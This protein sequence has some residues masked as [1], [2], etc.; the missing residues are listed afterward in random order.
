MPRVYGPKAGEKEKMS[1]ILA[2]KP[3][4][5]RAGTAEKSPDRFKPKVDIVAHVEKRRT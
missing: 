4:L 5:I 3:K 1:K 2:E